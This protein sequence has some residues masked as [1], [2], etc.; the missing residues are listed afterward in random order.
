MGQASK[1]LPRKSTGGWLGW[2][3]ES[4]CKEKAIVKNGACNL[5]RKKKRRTHCI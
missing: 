4:L 2:R 1:G 3:G 5:R